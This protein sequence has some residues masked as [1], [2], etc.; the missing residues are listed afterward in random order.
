MPPSRILAADYCSDKNTRYHIFWS[1]QEVIREIKKSST[2]KGLQNIPPNSFTNSWR[3]IVVI[4]DYSSM[5]YRRKQLMSLV[6]VCR[7]LQVTSLGTVNP[8][9]EDSMGRNATTCSATGEL[10]VTLDGTEIYHSV[11]T[12]KQWNISNADSHSTR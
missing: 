6:I 7:F 8:A 10:L 3:Y 11:Q 2:S 1:F 9:K 5:F 4:K 12:Q